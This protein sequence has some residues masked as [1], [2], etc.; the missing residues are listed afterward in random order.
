MR[1]WPIFMQ[2]E[3]TERGKGGSR[4]PRPYIHT[5]QIDRLIH[6]YVKVNIW[7]L[8]GMRTAY[9]HTCKLS[10][11]ELRRVPYGNGGGEAVSVT[12]LTRRSLSVCLPV[13]RPSLRRERGIKEAD[14]KSDGSQRVKSSSDDTYLEDM[15]AFMQLLPYI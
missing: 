7:H 4:V 11:S 8:P 14:S 10:S 1:L 13:F 9:C 6:G 12:T 2:I 5:L 3:T 15:A